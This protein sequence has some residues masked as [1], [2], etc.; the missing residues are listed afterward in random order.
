MRLL[1]W[2]FLLLLVPAVA[3]AQTVSSTTGALNGR[4]T[5]NTGAVLPGVAVTISSPSL[6]GTRTATTNEEGQ[7]R[8][9]AIP[10]G[11]YTITYEL[12]GFTTVKREGIRVGL[13]FTATVNIELGVATLQ[14]SVTVTGESPVVDTQA[15]NITTNFDAE[16]LANLP[17]ARDLWAILAQAPAISLT[18]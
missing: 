1:R 3:A 16:K 12:S 8:F 9:P 6:M 15:T 18:R 4:V 14:E 5:D 13:G 7:Y 11:E 2:A 17:N 10:P